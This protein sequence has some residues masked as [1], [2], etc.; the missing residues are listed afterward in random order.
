[1]FEHPAKA[2]SFGGTIMTPLESSIPCVCGD[3]ACKIPYGLCHCG[4]GGKAP[5]AKQNYARKGEI[6]G[7]PL[8]FIYQHHKLRL[9]SSR[10]FLLVE[11]PTKRENG[12]SIVCRE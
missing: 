6:K 7:K 3:S 5:L 10:A 9:A 8:R 12:R 2:S 4:C 1:M 11:E